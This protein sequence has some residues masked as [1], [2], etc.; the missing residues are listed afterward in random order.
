MVVFLVFF[1]LFF[2][3]ILFSFSFLFSF[4]LCFP[5]L[6]SVF[7]SFFFFSLP[8]PPHSCLYPGS[9]YCRITMQKSNKINCTLQALRI[10]IK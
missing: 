8:S 10:T 1:F 9:E 6:S 5:F 4:S 2:F 3:L 7:F